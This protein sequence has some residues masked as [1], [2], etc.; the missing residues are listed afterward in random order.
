[1][2]IELVVFDMAGTPVND[3]DSVSRCV[4]GA[5]AAH[6]VMVTVA[7]VNGVMGLPKPEALRILISESPRRV[8]LRRAVDPFLSD[9]RLGARGLRV[10]A[11]L[12]GLE[13]GRDQGGPQH[14]V[15]PRDHAKLLRVHTPGNSSSL[16]R[17]RNSL[18]LIPNCQRWSARSGH[19]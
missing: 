2:P 6:C 5:L 11:D 17:T 10:G 19:T 4:Q 9:R 18:L 8:A 13:A 3:E 7:D 14:R 15:Q 16:T 1:M 12:S